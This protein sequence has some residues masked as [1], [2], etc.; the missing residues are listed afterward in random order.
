MFMK[1][2]IAASVMLGL[3]VTVPIASFA[4][5]DN[6]KSASSTK[7][8]VHHKK[9]KKGFSDTVDENL[10]YLYGTAPACASPG[11]EYGYMDT[12]RSIGAAE[13]GY[14]PAYRRR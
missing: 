10:G 12:C 9:P 6:D 2:C 4:A 14:A 3:I 8:T 11:L 5:G 13:L 1:T 7:A